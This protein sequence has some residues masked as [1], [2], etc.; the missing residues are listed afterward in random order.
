MTTWTAYVMID[1]DLSSDPS[2]SGAL[3]TES[4]PLAD[5]DLEPPPWQVRTI[6][7]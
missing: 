2:L 7:A 5:R 4:G 1:I 3:A 6:P